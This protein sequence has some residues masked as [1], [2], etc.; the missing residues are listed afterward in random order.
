MYASERTTL[1]IPPNLAAALAYLLAWVSGIIV[2]LIEKDNRYVRFHAA[3]SVLVFGGLTVLGMLLPIAGNILGI[4]PLIGPIF[5]AILSIISF[6]LG[7]AALVT[8]VGLLLF[9]LFGRDYRV[10]YLESYADR[11]ARQTA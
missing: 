6:L 5:K 10:P 4:I 11:I 2:L 1:G 7:L 8:W 3:Q 9:A